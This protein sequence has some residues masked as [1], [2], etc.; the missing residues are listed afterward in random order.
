MGINYY[1][2]YFFEGNCQYFM[3][4]QDNLD[5]LKSLM[6]QYWFYVKNNLEENEI[7]CNKML[8]QAIY[9]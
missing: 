1:L 3:Q 7:I 6:E 2:I 9:K 5:E 8:S 4:G